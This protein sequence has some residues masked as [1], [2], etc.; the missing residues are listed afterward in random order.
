V[1]NVQ[2]Y[3]AEAS[4]PFDVTWDGAKR[5]SLLT[6]RELPLPRRDYSGY[7]AGPMDADSHMVN[8]KTF[9]PHI[10]SPPVPDDCIV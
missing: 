1:Q 8:R 5:I 9:V 2:L 10:A 6:G 7:E 4:K 3:D